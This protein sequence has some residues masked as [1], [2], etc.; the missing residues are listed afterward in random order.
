MASASP[1]KPP[2]RDYAHRHTSSA[3]GRLLTIAV[4]VVIIAAIV[5]TYFWYGR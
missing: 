2:L 5:G 3:G 1:T 4:I